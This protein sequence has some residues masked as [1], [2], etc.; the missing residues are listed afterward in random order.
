MVFDINIHLP[1]RESNLQG[2]LREESFMRSKELIHGFNHYHDEFSDIMGG[3][4]M[5]F[6]ENIEHNEIQIFS[7][8]VRDKMKN[9]FFT[10]LTNFR[11]TSFDYLEK[12]KE[13]GVS[14]IKFHSYV[15]KISDLD[16]DDVL[17][18]SKNAEKLGLPIFIDTSYGTSKMYQHDNLKLAAFLLDHIKSV[19]VVLL[20][21]GG[22]RVLEAFL[23]AASCDNV[24]LDSSFSVDTY[25]GSSV[26]IDLAYTYN[27]IGFDRVV[28]GSDMPYVSSND[29]LNSI[30]KFFKNQNINLDYQN[31]ML[32][33][34]WKKIFYG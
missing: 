29:S 25:L 21:S 31:S 27:Q 18:C 20:H 13:S 17:E 22:S 11:F 6:N 30:K 34:S 12:M 26:E 23:L 24:F 28:Y 8:Y 5:I 7:N 32:E 2:F 19:P 16:F 10:L 15:Q 14:A 3:N 9:S 33:E 4:F 1:H